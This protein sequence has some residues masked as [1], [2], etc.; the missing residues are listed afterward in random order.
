MIRLEKKAVLDAGFNEGWML[1]DPRNVYTAGAL[2][3]Q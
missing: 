1:W 3:L 2:D